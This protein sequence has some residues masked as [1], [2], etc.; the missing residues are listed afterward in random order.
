MK[1]NHSSHT[2]PDRHSDLRLP[3]PP[4]GAMIAW[5]MGIILLWLI[6]TDGFIDPQPTPAAAPP[7]IIS[8]PG[9]RDS[10]TEWDELPGGGIAWR[11][12]RGDRVAHPA[13]DWTLTQPNAQ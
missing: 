7:W 8:W 4:I 3:N 9:G 12:L 2:D 5:S 10:A 13:G 11:N 6:V 1:P